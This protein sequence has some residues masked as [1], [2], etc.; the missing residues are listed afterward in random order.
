MKGNIPTYA[1]TNQFDVKKNRS[2]SD[3]HKI[4]NTVYTHSNL[5]NLFV[6]IKVIYIE[7]K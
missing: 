3:Q 6:G 1:E 7:T 2:R 5:K 4:K